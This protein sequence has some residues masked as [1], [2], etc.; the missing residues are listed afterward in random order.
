[1][2]LDENNALAQ[3]AL[4]MSRFMMLEIDSAVTA[5]RHTLNLNPNL[6]AAEAWLAVMLSWRGD[7][8]EA[9][10]HADKA[11]RLNPHDS[12]SL[13]SVGPTSAYFAAGHYE[14]AVASARKMIE[15]VPESPV[16]LRYLISSLAHLG[17]MDEA[18]AAKDRLLTVVPG[19]NLRMLKA[20]LP[21]GN[22]ERLDRFVDGLRKAGV[23]E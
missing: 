18:R 19:Q 22:A 10:Q 13:W 12:H 9:L 14:E 15:A 23:P 17:R 11:V 6:A 7:Y 3:V 1:V 2:E 20:H 16:P 8:D 4:S 5:N 21:S